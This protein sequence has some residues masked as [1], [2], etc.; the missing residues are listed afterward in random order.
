MYGRDNDVRDFQLPAP[1]I[2]SFITNSSLHDPAKS[3]F[4]TITLLCTQCMGD[5]A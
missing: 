5:L 2:Y 4:A 1:L 3:A